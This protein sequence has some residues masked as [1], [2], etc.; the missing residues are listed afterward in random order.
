M[1]VD[2]QIIYLFDPLCGWCY[3]A[4]PA[5][6]RLAQEPGV[7]IHPAPIGLFTGEGARPMDETFAEYAWTNDQ[8]IEQLTGQRF[9]GVYRSEVLADRHRMLDSGPATLALTAVS[10]AA[11]ER[12]LEA[13]QAIQEARFVDGRDTTAL[14]VLAEILTTL[15]LVSASSRLAT[16]DDELLNANQIRI[17]GAQDEMKAIGARGVPALIVIDG[18]TRR[19]LNSTALFSSFKDLQSQLK[20]PD[21]VSASGVHT[22]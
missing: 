14:P 22:V 6:Q 11:P 18:N 17:T 7:T 15:N 3:G 9:T 5:I 4:S 19:L 21:L 2:T 16:P 1:T 8:R 12:E 13:L 20:A 10:L